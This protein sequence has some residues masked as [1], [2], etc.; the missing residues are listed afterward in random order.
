MANAKKANV[1][2]AAKP[3]PRAATKMEPAKRA[4][5]LPGLGGKP[6]REPLALQFAK[7]AGF[8]KKGKLRLPPAK[9]E[10][11]SF[12]Q[13]AHSPVQPGNLGGDFR[14]E[15]K[16]DLPPTHVLGLA[17]KKKQVPHAATAIIGA[18]AVTILISAL[19]IFIMRIGWQYALPISAAIF[20]GF[21]ILFYNYLE[22]RG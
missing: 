17:G 11:F 9:S 15:G 20:A 8:A 3:K 2:K 22:E 19:F 12:P 1:A 6:N 21:A 7:S 14:Q 13:P 4:S 18:L 5:R 16:I 10:T